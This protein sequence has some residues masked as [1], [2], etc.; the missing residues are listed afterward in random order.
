MPTE[1]GAYSGMINGD[2]EGLMIQEILMIVI[3]REGMGEW[4]EIME[5]IC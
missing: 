2:N 1:P 3:I 5:L 4:K